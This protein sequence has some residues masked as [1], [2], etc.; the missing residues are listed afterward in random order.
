MAAITDV[1]GP[2]AH[3][4]FAW[5]RDE[6]R[7]RA[8]LELQQVLLDGEGRPVATWGSSARPN[9]RPIPWRDRGHCC[10]EARAS[11]RG[12]GDGRPAHD[13]R[14]RLS[15]LLLRC[16]APLAH[17]ARLDR[18]GPDPRAGLAAPRQVPRLA[19]RQAGRA[20]A[21]PHARILPCLPCKSRSH[22]KPS[23]PTCVPAMALDPV[24]P[25]LSADVPRPATAAAG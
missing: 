4:F 14:S 6:T 13:G 22:R 10:R 3:P 19:A 16:R 23:A 20:G 1:T 12:R 17:S 5:M 8:R 21:V 24:E 2:E 9:G 15:R 25:G 18:A 7:L 11:G